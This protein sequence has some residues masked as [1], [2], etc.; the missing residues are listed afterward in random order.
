M[1][2]VMATFFALL[3]GD[4]EV[5]AT[6]HYIEDK[7]IDT[8]RVVGKTSL[9]VRSDKSYLWH[10][11]ALYEDGCALMDNATQSIAS[12]DQVSCDPQPIETLQIPGTNYNTF[13]TQLQIDALARKGFPLIDATEMTQLARRFGGVF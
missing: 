10:V 11:L 6:L 8:G 9:P 5:G 13:P 4:D 2:A 7:R 12:G 1:L 3:N